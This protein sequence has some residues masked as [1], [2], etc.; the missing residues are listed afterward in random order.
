MVALLQ[1]SKTLFIGTVI[2]MINGEN[3]GEK[4]KGIKS[5]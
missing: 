2:W 4:K 3:F 1:D 5:L